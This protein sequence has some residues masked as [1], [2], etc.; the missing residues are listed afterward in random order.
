MQSSITVWL[1]VWLPAPAPKVLVA[2][3]MAYFPI[4]LPT[5]YGSQKKALVS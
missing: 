2:K 3:D 5:G 4:W 1:P